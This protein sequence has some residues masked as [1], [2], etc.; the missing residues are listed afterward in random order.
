MPKNETTGA[1]NR[2]IVTRRRRNIT[3]LIITS[4]TPAAT[5]AAASSAKYSLNC[6][7]THDRPVSKV[8]FASCSV[9]LHSPTASS[10]HSSPHRA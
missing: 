7:M 2:K 6:P 9:M 1:A 8:A 10:D 3:M 4:T 5:R